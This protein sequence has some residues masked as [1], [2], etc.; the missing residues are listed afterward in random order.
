MPYISHIALSP[1]W[2]KS[3]DP[4]LDHLNNGHMTIPSA[5]FRSYQSVIQMVERLRRIPPKPANGVPRKYQR[6]SLWSVCQTYQ[7]AFRTA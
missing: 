1:Q 4:D 5:G 7:P 2:G 3:D 6:V